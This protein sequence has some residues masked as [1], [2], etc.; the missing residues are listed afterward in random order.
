M[1]LA[2]RL[3]CMDLIQAWALY[4]DQ[5]RWTELLDTFYPEGRIAVTW[6]AGPFSEFVARSQKAAQVALTAGSS[7]KHQIGWPILSFAGDRAV[8]ETNVSILGRQTLNGVQVDNISY[9][10]FLD[11]LEKRGGQWRILERVAIYEK[12]RLDPVIPG[13]AF[14]RLMAESDFSVYPEAY[15]FLAHR[16]VS[17]GRTLA[18]P[19]LC[20]GSAETETLYRRY[21]TWLGNEV[22]CPPNGR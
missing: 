18:S 8:A 3:A 17:A 22:D 9:G 14:D 16:L 12:D 7:S 6:F 19:I 5:G 4:R 15:R 21:Q 13:E 10:R 11:R 2:D 1:E 20:H